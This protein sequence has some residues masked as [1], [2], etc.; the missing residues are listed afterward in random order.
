MRNPKPEIRNLRPQTL[1]PKQGDDVIDLLYICEFTLNFYHS[2][3][4][5][6]RH[7]RKGL[8]VCR[9]LQRFRGGLVFKAHRLCVLL[10]S[11]LE[12]NKEEK[13]WL[14][15][16]LPTLNPQPSTLNPQPA[17]RNPQ[18]ATINPQPQPYPLN[19]KP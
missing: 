4:Q 7:Q 13:I 12:S 5:L 14:A 3:A 10:N 15:R 18:P 9:N 11:R 8:S 17:T 16:A 6:E 1:N 19:P 2:K